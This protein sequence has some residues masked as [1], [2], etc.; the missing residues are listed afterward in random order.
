[1]KTDVFSE[2]DFKKNYGSSICLS[3]YKKNTN[4]GFV[5]IINGEQGGTDWTCLQIKN[6]KSCYFDSFGGSPDKNVFKQLPKPII[7]HK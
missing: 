6:K 1:M 3:G 7:C 4:E 2:S 5:D